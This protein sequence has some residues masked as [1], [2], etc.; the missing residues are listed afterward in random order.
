MTRILTDVNLIDNTFTITQLSWEAELDDK[1]LYKIIISNSIIQF[2]S[3]D[4]MI[5][6]CN[7]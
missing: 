5:K 1:K 2:F 3:R 4:K 7:L 6:T